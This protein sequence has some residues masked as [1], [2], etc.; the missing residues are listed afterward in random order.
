VIPS[1]QCDLAIIGGGPAGI[2]AA[3]VAHRLDLDVCLVDEQHRFGGQIYRQP[4]REFQVGN[5]LSGA[6]YQRAKAQI[7]EVEQLAALRHIAPATAWACFPSSG[8]AREG[9]R[10]DVLYHNDT[11]LGRVRARHVLIAS[12]CYEA[13]VPFP[14][15]QLPGV[16]SAGGIQT[17][18]KSQ[19]VAAGRSIFLAGSHPLL[20]VAAQQLTAAGVRIA[21][22]ALMQ[23]V[24]TA[25]HLARSPR[26][27]WTG[28]G[29]LFGT[30]RT[31][32][33]LRR[34]GVPVWFGHA[35]IEALG[36]REIEGVRL[37]DLASA[38]EV[39]IACDALGV[40]YGFLPSSE[41]ARQAGAEHFWAP[42]GGWV[43][44]CD[45]YMRS[46][47]PGISVAGELT[48][49]AGAQAAALSGEIAGLG[50]T[51]DLGRL[52]ASQSDARMLP[53]RKR[54]MRLRRFATVLA[55]IAA[56]APQLLASLAQRPAVLCRCE[57]I[58]V[59]AL[60]DAVARNVDLLSASTAKLATRA[61]MGFCQGRMC[62]LS[63]RR[64][65][66]RHRNCRLD[67]VP[68]FVIRPPIKP[69]PLS[70]LA[71]LPGALGI[72]PDSL[73]RDPRGVHP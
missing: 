58:T 71:E 56:P 14:G 67:E 62:E 70:L 37:R 25:W 30:L 3:I 12:G 46:S 16:M 51:R 59:G 19:R 60:E 5:W 44:R 45:E 4:P 28:S 2:A 72:D 20:L 15:W 54:W 61:G 31:L 68:G 24:T 13:P 10:H 21:G 23:P 33:E 42:E 35:V 41:L 55:H 36:T 17:L 6:G 64:I 50:V 53:L 32:I 66:A 43:T 40:C 63:V 48:G 34:R 1:Q 11:A 52:T 69:V 9:F 8:D 39:E 22:I 29:H 73:T 38:R 57:D 18:L 47:V 27:M 49:V 65:L 7:R 26:A